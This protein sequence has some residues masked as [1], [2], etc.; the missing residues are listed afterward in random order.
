LLALKYGRNDAFIEQHWKKIVI[1][2]P[3]IR[4][5][6]LT[7]TLFRATVVYMSKVSTTFNHKIRDMDNVLTSSE[8]EVFKPYVVELFEQGMEKG[9]E[10]GMEQG[11]EKALLSFMGKNMDWP[12]DKIANLFDVPVSLVEK[13]RNMLTQNR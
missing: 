5:E 10:K 2:A 12:D 6:P 7:L 11:I 1:F 9:I 4:D 3:D 8:Q 13:L